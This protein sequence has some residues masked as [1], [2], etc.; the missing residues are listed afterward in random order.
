MSDEQRY[1]RVAQILEHARGEVARTVNTAMVRASWLIGRQIVEVEQAGLAGAGYSGEALV[2]AIRQAPLAGSG[3]QEPGIGQAS[4]AGSQRG[5]IRSTLSSES[6][7]PDNRSIH[8]TPSG[9]LVGRPPDE[10]GES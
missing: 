7:R 4:L 8:Q 3:T 6:T 10:G 9:E 2:P 1:G 5:S